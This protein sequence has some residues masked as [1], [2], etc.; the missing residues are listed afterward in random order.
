MKTS[1]KFKILFSICCV[2]L[3]V[4]LL[5]SVMVFLESKKMMVDIK[6]ESVSNLQAEFTHNVAYLFH[7]SSRLV[8]SIAEREEMVKYF[9]S[10]SSSTGEA[11]LN[12]LLSI[13][14]TDHPEYLALYVLN[15]LGTCIASTDRR[16]IREDYS[17]RPYFIQAM[18]GEAYSEVVLGKTS[19]ELGYYFSQPITLENN[20]VVGVAVIKLRPDHIER[21]L[22]DNE[23]AKVGQVMLVDSS[24]IILFA[25]R[26][27]RLLHSL[28]SLNANEIDS[29][30]SEQKFLDVS[31]KPIQYDNIQAL[32]R[33]YKEPTTIDFFDNTDKETKM[34]GIHQ[35]APYPY[36]IIT[37]VHID[38]LVGTAIHLAGI[39]GISVL[40]AAILAALIIVYFM[41][42]FLK[43]LKRITEYANIVSKGDFNQTIEI[44]SG[45]E[46]E[47]LA[48]TLNTMTLRIKGL[49]NNLESTIH[50]QTQE[51]TE[52]VKQLEE[53]RSKT[54]L[55]LKELESEKELADHR[56]E[57]LRKYQLAVENV[58]DHIVITD[59]DGNILYANKAV[60]RITGY[61]REEI[62]GTKAGVKWGKLMSNE[63]Y[64]KLWTEI[65][66]NKHSF[67]GEFTN[68]RKNGESYI[69]EARISPILDEHGDVIF[70]VGIERDITK[71]RE[72]DRMKTEFIS[73]ASHQLRTP[74]SAMKWF[75]EM[76]LVGD[77]GSLSTEQ[78]EI[79]KNINESNERMIE[80]V[81]TLLDVSR[82]ESGR[83]VIDPK[84]TDLRVLL[85]ELLSEIESSLRGKNQTIDVKIPDNMQQI[86]ID[87]KLTR[88]VL[89]NFLTNAI[90][91]SPNDATISLIITLNQKEML[92]T[93]SDQGYGIPIEDQDKIFKKFFR[94]PSVVKRAVEGNGLG[95]YLVK[96]IIESSGGKVWF[97][98][99][100]GKGTSFYFS[101]PLVT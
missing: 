55:L 97:E 28:G 9:K 36:F 73:L 54:H 19:N 76:L 31:I 18:K 79:I 66:L 22:K 5:A 3:V 86:L 82:I 93:I 32:I 25:Q 10:P 46:F 16:F 8:Q 94:S 88:Q 34:F 85:N 48:K 47:V 98:S 67:V 13:Y 6:R 15:R 59:A 49:Y 70:F 44:K 30:K 56:A 95:L 69:A 52:E 21:R 27:D 41:Y 45:D 26:S 99:E 68:R 29:L 78:K 4:G 74:L 17:F 80:L 51:L 23:L 12:K 83:L 38:N 40:I 37:E 96:S 87:P 61:T 72:I 91:Y 62:M 65:K 33:S 84:L 90:K 81:N 75:L 58:S 7:D 60:E 50:E 100:E 53:A 43:P 57:D 35:I 64:Q 39:L 77:L 11:D 92:C 89:M 71:L 20:D 63:L 2:I 42:G 101:L 14:N 1:L 24:G